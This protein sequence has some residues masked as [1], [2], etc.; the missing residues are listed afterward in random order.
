M[1]V[2]HILA[3]RENIPH[4]IQ[5]LNSTRHFEPTFRTFPDV[6]IAEEDTGE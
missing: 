2:R 1:T 5:Y 3:Q 6:D 4:L